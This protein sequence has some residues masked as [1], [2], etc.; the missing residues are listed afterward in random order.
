[1]PLANR[2]LTIGHENDFVRRI[3]AWNAVGKSV[4]SPF[5][6]LVLLVLDCRQVL[7]EEDTDDR[8]ACILKPGA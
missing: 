8:S 6:I 1:M 3:D 2:C 5:L 7:E 4:A